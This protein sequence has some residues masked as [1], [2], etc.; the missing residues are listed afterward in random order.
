MAMANGMAAESFF[1]FVYF[2]FINQCHCGIIVQELKTIQIKAPG[3]LAMYAREK[4][5]QL[6]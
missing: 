5:I 6:Q 3:L 4:Y 1:K 2:R